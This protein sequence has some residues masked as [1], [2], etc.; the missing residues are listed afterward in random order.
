MPPQPPL[1]VTAMTLQA[2]ELTL[3]LL[4]IEVSERM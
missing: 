3:G 2:L 4:G 1:G